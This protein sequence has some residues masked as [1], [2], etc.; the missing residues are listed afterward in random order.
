MFQIVLIVKSAKNESKLS[1]RFWVVVDFVN[2]I[3]HFLVALRQSRT[4]VLGHFELWNALPRPP[5]SMLGIVTALTEMCYMCTP[6]LIG[7][8]R[9][10]FEEVKKQVNTTLHMISLNDP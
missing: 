9:E 2:D 6:T 1:N 7:G 4:K 5:E 8:G 3:A 10:G